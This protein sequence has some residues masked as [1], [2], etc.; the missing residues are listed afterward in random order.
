MDCLF[1]FK[2]LNLLEH[3]GVDALLS[4]TTSYLTLTMIESGEI[5]AKHDLPNISFASGGDTVCD[6]NIR[7]R[8]VIYQWK[9]DIFFSSFWAWGQNIGYTRFRCLRCQ[10][11][12]L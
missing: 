1:S 8:S 2:F 11:F 9:F 6:W 3:A 4:I 12:A 7:F 5:L 10:R